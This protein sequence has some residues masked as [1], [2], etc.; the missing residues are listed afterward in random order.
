MIVKNL[1]DL[2]DVEY[3]KLLTR[4]DMPLSLA[5]VG[6]L[7][8]FFRK[9]PPT[10]QKAEIDHRESELGVYGKGLRKVYQNQFQLAVDLTARM[11]NALRLDSSTTRFEL[12]PITRVG[13]YVPVSLPS[14]LLTIAAN[15][16]GAG[17]EELVVITKSPLTN[18]FIQ[19]AKIAGL[20]EVYTV[21]SA[22]VAP[23]A[24]AF[25]IEGMLEP[26]EKVVGPCSPYIDAIKQV[27]PRYGVAIDMRANSSELVSFVGY[28]DK[29]KI[30]VRR[31]MADVLAQAEHSQDETP[32]C[33]VLTD[34]VET[35]CRLYATGNELAGQSNNPVM[36]L[37]SPEVIELV[38][39]CN[40]YQPELLT[41]WSDNQKSIDMWVKGTS[42]GKVYVNTSSVL[43][44]YGVVGTGCCDPTGGIA[45]SGISALSFLKLRSVMCRTPSAQDIRYASAIADSENLPYHKKAILEALK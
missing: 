19:A 18:P 25:G 31:I 24:L 13:A 28:K 29:T 7:V 45:Q 6:S 10:V 40:R 38:N 15:A 16:N 17:V 22:K 43:G 20:D 35:A 5:K 12:I 32:K 39:F 11:S 34:D 36:L 14:T 27:L 30:P 1:R 4:P 41:V 33:F 8:A 26:V 23:L 2:T 3:K 42:V 37:Y 44:D 21:T 9:S